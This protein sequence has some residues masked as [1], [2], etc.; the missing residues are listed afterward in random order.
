MKVLIKDIVESEMILI[1]IMILLSTINV[2]YAFVE[3]KGSNLPSNI[4]MKDALDRQI[5]RSS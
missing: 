4:G 5:N 3:K 2:F 1:D